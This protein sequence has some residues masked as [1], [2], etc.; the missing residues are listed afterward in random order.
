MVEKFFVDKDS[1][2]RFFLN[3]VGKR[4]TDTTA[5]VWPGSSQARGLVHLG[6]LVLIV[7]VLSLRSLTPG[8]EPM[9]QEMG[10]VL[11]ADPNTAPAPVHPTPGA[12]PSDSRHATADRRTLVPAP[13]AILQ[14]LF[15]SPLPTP[16]VGG[17]MTY[18][19]QA[20]DNLVDLALRFGLTRETL[21]WAN[22]DLEVDPGALYVGQIL[23]ILPIDGVYYTI[24]EGDTPAGV[25]AEFGV[26]MAAILDCP[27]NLLTR[28]GEHW[29]P[30]Q[31][32]IVPG[33]VKP[34]MPS[35]V[36][37]D[38]APQTPEPV[39]GTEAFVWP[40]G[41]YISQGYW[42]LHRALD[43]AGPQGDLILAAAS[44]KVVYA[45]WHNAGY[46]N[47]V[48]VDHGNGWTTYYGHLYGFYVDVG[49]QV[50]LGQPV[51]A[52]GNTGRST[53][54]HLHFEMRRGHALYSPLDFLPHG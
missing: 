48:I 24:K 53:G 10:P 41:G 40:V 32:I 11:S 17:V 27:Y 12:P 14:T 6:L 2:I 36:V 54:P 21:I 15:V 9:L 51:G 45:Q 26:D 35:E 28:E 47:L 16:D 4:I 19:V 44:G 38:P 37:Y 34:F 25:A 23:N 31:K 50:Q 1:P 39:Q 22:P 42:N 3:R 7:F 33:G 20:G 18:T 49:D 46:G 52:R 13:V 30:G 5:R 43:I 8:Q 29:V